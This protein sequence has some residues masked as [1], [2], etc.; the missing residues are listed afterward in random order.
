MLPSFVYIIV[1]RGL[2]YLSSYT[3]YEAAVAAV[4][5]KNK[6]TLQYEK[7]LAEEMGEPLDSEIDIPENTVTQTTT[8]FLS[9]EKTT[10]LVCKVAVLH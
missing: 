10:I 3:T 9:T 6:E 1:Q 7:E 8:L 5:E 4:K 2:P